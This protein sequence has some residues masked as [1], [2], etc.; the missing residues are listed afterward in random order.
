M[1]MKKCKECGAE[2]SS[3]AKKCPSCGKDQRNWFSRHKLLTVIL[4]I[5][6]IGIIG[7]AIPSATPDTPVAPDTPPI[8]VTVDTLA[9]DLKDNALNA[10]NTYKNK[11]VEVTGLLENI[12]SDGAYFTIGILSGGFSMDTVMCNITKEQQDIV[13]TLKDK[14]KVTVTGTITMVGEV[15]GYA[16]E[17]E[18][19]K[20]DN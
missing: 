14:Q 6:V 5:V 2:I 1:A 15:L 17:V 9:K 13:S 19:I 10:S 18:S 3:S 16:M 11:Y 4:A 8:V 20:I 12:D 7:S